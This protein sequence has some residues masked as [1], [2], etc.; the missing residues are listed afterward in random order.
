MVVGPWTD[1]FIARLPADTRI[2]GALLHPGRASSWLGLP[3]A[4]L[5]N[6]TVPLRLVRGQQGFGREHQSS[7][8]VQSCPK[9]LPSSERRRHPL[10]RVATSLARSACGG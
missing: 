8:E 10:R 9:Y 4:E 6:R 1:P 3:A 2:V 5:L 7:M